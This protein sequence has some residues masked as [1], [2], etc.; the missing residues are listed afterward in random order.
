MKL[1]WGVVSTGAASDR[2]VGPGIN[3]ESDSRIVAVYSR[4]REKADAYAAKH[5]ADHAYTSYEE[6]LSDAAVN[7][8]YIASPNGLH[9]EQAIQAAEAGK[10]VFCEK[11]LA[12]N[13]TDARRVIE[14]CKKA[15][16]KLGVDFQTRHYAP[17]QEAVRLIRE[18]VVGELRVLQIECCAP[19][20]ALK[21]WRTDTALSG[22][23]AVNNLAVHPLDLA[24][25]LVGSEVAEV[26][27]LTNAGRSD[28]LE[29]IALMTMRFKNGALAY[30]N[31][32]QSVPNPR[33]D[34]DLYGSAGRISGRSTTRPFMDGELLV[35]SGGEERSTPFS[36]KDGFQRAIASFNQSV[37][38]NTE[39][40]ASG[41]DG[42]RSVEL[43]DAIAKSARTGAV[44]TL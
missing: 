24:R 38:N 30:V 31:G 2:L 10:H 41:E 4:E 7:V 32:S 37:L 23:G 29:T 9:A 28:E 14:A 36:T 3:A 8:V 27:A 6:L 13:A 25:Y 21:G 1:G 12:L 15:G 19:S 22:M 39:P 17:I 16:V 40:N 20:G 43:V 18:G 26:V 33:P 11:P 44:V 42:L 35:V 34:M 5:G